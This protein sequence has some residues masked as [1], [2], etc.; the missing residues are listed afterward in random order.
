MDD[1]LR[2]VGNQGSSSARAKGT[3]RNRHYSTEAPPWKLDPKGCGERRIGGQGSARRSPW[4]FLRAGFVYVA[5][6]PTAA[7]AQPPTRSGGGFGRP[8]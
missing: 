3:R 4:R 7:A 5:S 2:R 6:M 1:Q 8:E